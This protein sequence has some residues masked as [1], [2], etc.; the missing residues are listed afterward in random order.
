ML[1]WKRIAKVV[2]SNRSHPI[3]WNLNQEASTNVSEPTV[4]RPLHHFG[5]SSRGPLPMTIVGL[6][7]EQ[8]FSVHEG[9]QGLENR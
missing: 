3:T 2:Q 9:S 4:R 8:T 7:Q 5:I 1:V 6:E